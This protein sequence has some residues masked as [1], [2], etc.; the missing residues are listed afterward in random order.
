ML[1][2][3][4]ESVTLPTQSGP[5]NVTLFRPADAGRYPGVVF[6]SEIFQITGP[7]RRTAAMLAGHGHVVAVPEIFHELEAPGCVLAYDKPGADRGNADKVGKP[8]SAYDDDCRVCLD[9]LEADESCNGRLGAMGICI[10][11][12]LAFRAAMHPRCRAAACYYPTD[13]HSA[14]LGRGGDDSL[15]RVG[16]IKGEMLMIFGRQDPHIPL[17]GRDLIRAALEMAGVTY[18]WHEFNAQHAFI[19][20]EGHRY[21]P[22]LSSICAQMTLEM[23]RRRLGVETETPGTGGPGRDE[24]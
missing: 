16:E 1:I 20:D 8:V 5:M 19:R 15:R 13:I 2:R 23:F 9:L 14:T 21:D 12:H 18:Q 3:E 24:C 22:A 17:A 7:I 6:F 10:G 11:G 4:P